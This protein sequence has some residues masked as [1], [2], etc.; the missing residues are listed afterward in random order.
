MY[1]LLV[2][3]VIINLIILCGAVVNKLYI[4]Y[5]NY[6][7]LCDEIKPAHFRLKMLGKFNNYN[8][9]LFILLE[10]FY[11]RYFLIKCVKNLLFFKKSRAVVGSI[12]KLFIRKFIKSVFVCL[13]FYSITTVSSSPKTAIISRRS[14]LKP[15]QR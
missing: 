11:L 9:C 15:Y 5:T 8:Y 7:E 2:I 10:F 12:I 13:T 14:P 1:F 6:Q 4:V 3:N